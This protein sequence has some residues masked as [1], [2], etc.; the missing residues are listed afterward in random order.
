MALKRWSQI[1]QELA[2]RGPV[3]EK[4]LNELRS[5]YLDALAREGSFFSAAPE[6]QSAVLDELKESPPYYKEGLAGVGQSAW[7][8]LT[9]GVSRLPEMG[10]IGPRTIESLLNRLGIPKAVGAPD[11]VSESGGLFQA[12]L[13]KVSEGIKYLI[14]G[15]DESVPHGLVQNVAAGAAGLPA[16]LIRLAPF[17]AAGAATAG[18]ATP[19]LAGRVATAASLENGVPLALTG[20]AKI[21]SNSLA[22][23]VGF[24]GSTAVEAFNQT[25]VPLGD[26]AAETAKSTAL[27]AALGPAGA[28]SSPLL[29][30]LAEAG[31][32]A[33]GAVA[34]STDRIFS[35]GEPGDQARA[36]ALVQALLPLGAHGVKKLM[37][38]DRKPG[39]PV[40][41]VKTEEVP[42]ESVPAEVEP[43]RRDFTKK[44]DEVYQT[45][46]EA[47]LEGQ[48]EP[49]QVLIRSLFEQKPKDEW[50]GKA[51]PVKTEEVPP[52]VGG[53]TPPVRPESPKPEP[54]PVAEPVKTD[55]QDPQDVSTEEGFKAFVRKSGL[56][57]EEVESVWQEHL[58]ETGQAPVSDEPVSLTDP[59]SLANQMVV[60]LRS[61]EIDGRHWHSFLDFAAR[62]LGLAEEDGRVNR[63]TGN[64]AG[65]QRFL[66]VK[67]AASEA[68]LGSKELAGLVP[69]FEQVGAPRDPRPEHFNP[70]AP[71][72][73][74]AGLLKR[75]S[76]VIGYQ[77]LRNEADAKFG[78]GR[79][80][81]GKPTVKS[82]QAKVKT[83]ELD[84]SYGMD[85][86]G[87]VRPDARAHLAP[88]EVP[89]ATGREVVL[90]SSGIDESLGQE[91][92][93]RNPET[94]EPIY[95]GVRSDRAKQEFQKELPSRKAL[96]VA[97]MTD[98]G[99]GAQIH[100]AV[101]E[102][103]ANIPRGQQKVN[104][105][106]ISTWG[107]LLYR[108]GGKNP[109]EFLREFA[110]AA[111]EHSTPELFGR[112]EKEYGTT[113]A[114]KIFYGSTAS[115]STKNSSVAG[116]YDNRNPRKAGPYARRVI[117]LYRAATPAIFRHEIG[118]LMYDLLPESSKQILHGAI[119][120][121]KK[122]DKTQ[123]E[124]AADL[125]RRYVETG[126]SLPGLV[127]ETRA[128]REWALENSQKFLGDPELRKMLTPAVES[129]LNRLARGEP[130]TPFVDSSGG[131]EGSASFSEVPTQPAGSGKTEQE[132]AFLERA[133]EGSVKDLRP[134]THVTTRPPTAI[135]DGKDT[136]VEL[137]G[138]G[139]RKS[140]AQ[141]FKARKGLP[142]NEV[143]YVRFRQREGELSR[144][145]Y[146]LEMPGS[147]P[148]APVHGAV[149]SVEG[150]YGETSS[151]SAAQA[152]LRDLAA[153]GK[154]RQDQ[155]EIVS[156]YYRFLSRKVGVDPARNQ[157]LYEA[158]ASIKSVDPADPD[159]P[160]RYIG[161]EILDG[162]A[163]EASYDPKTRTTSWF[164][165]A[166]KE[167]SGLRLTWESFF[168]PLER[169][170]RDSFEGGV[171]LTNVA[172][173]AWHLAR[174]LSQ[175]YMESLNKTLKPLD[176]EGVTRFAS[177]V[178]LGQKPGKGL[179]KDLPE[180]SKALEG[181]GPR[182]A[183]VEKMIFE[184]RQGDQRSSLDRLLY[185]KSL[186]EQLLRPEL[187][188]RIR[189][190]GFYAS[191][192]DQWGGARGVGALEVI[193]RKNQAKL[194]R[195]PAEEIDRILSF[196]EEA[197]IP[198]TAAAHD[199][200][201]I[202]SRIAT[203]AAKARA[204]SRNGGE[205]F[206]AFDE[207]L[208]GSIPG[209]QAEKDLRAYRDLV[210][211]RNSEGSLNLLV[212]K[213]PAMRKAQGW[214]ISAALTGRAILGNSIS[215][216]S[217][218][219]LTNPAQWTDAL[220]RTLRKGGLRKESGVALG[221]VYQSPGAR[222]ALSQFSNIHPFAY[223]ERFVR[224]FAKNLGDVRLEK[225]KK[226][227]A[228]QDRRALRELARFTTD[229][230][231]LLR[232]GIREAQEPGSL[233][234]LTALEMA[235]QYALPM[236]KWS[237]P[238]QWQANQLVKVLTTLKRFS[239][240][241][242]I[243]VKNATVKNFVDG[244]E[245]WR[246]GDRANGIKL[247]NEAAARLAGFGL[248]GAVAGSLVG[249][250]WTALT[251]KW[252]QSVFSK[253]KGMTDDDRNDAIQT[254]ELYIKAVVDSG[255]TG[256]MADLLG[257]AGR[258]V[259][260]Q[261]SNLGDSVI[262][263]N[264]SRL[265]DTLG[266]MG[267]FTGGLGEIS[268]AILKE[269]GSEVKTQLR[270]TARKTWNFGENVAPILKTSEAPRSWGARGLTDLL[271]PGVE[272]RRLQR[273]ITDSVK[274]KDRPGAQRALVAY[275][276]FARKQ[277][278]QAR[279]PEDRKHWKNVLARLT[280]VRSYARIKED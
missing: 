23:G 268:R 98:P 192:R 265:Q 33:G 144:D 256:L 108:L 275:R 18:A 94:G 55:E 11:W 147:T 20:L 227:A 252:D 148:A 134:E 121:G 143:K 154:T 183:E 257:E 24:G 64:P 52:E 47:A 247:M 258:L 270:K 95:L 197:N 1:L 69:V 37:G 241:Q 253:A 65:V 167:K 213:S 236:D 74:L 140:L 171:K 59:Q 99:L 186:I 152:L 48:P 217:F 223:S 249:G 233:T 170:V 30:A 178:V 199:P 103:G 2:A 149:F 125:L 91:I 128:L 126:E 279:A 235:R 114:R 122:L 116:L 193:L 29:R 150:E 226:R 260:G 198:S 109:E 119:G 254:F 242:F 208:Q 273:Q 70:E 263:F 40:K 272:A 163:L 204:F 155:Y 32:F 175:P 146:A 151:R 231:D 138:A 39:E 245:W 159:A 71:E 82:I 85:S 176:R 205:V 62:A 112:L 49:I 41:P 21:L 137:Y 238:A 277:L 110:V 31:L 6:E 168:K 93:T 194:E 164:L 79:A 228:A 274:A 76:R 123:K 102:S 120:A 57:E 187:L 250:I 43:P 156:N 185:H 243:Q 225:L 261:K 34:G 54:E 77:K 255:F 83:G 10:F 224:G 202:I 269:N 222:D 25:D 234:D 117:F 50:A 124:T 36:E 111:G 219:P 162:T 203:D 13:D 51:E 262:G 182:L 101:V 259:Q 58:R 133:R 141:A 113:L 46:I 28:I 201:P 180:V 244:L 246:K 240:H 264:L 271:D 214:A 53:V 3:S 166:T 169:V 215:V 229:I 211:D 12:G 251:G 266:F 19:L 157:H 216:L 60:A 280:S 276:T 15:D 200:G 44:T 173:F 267:D 206:R 45:D 7:N 239:L 27:G 118:H 189:S 8:S 278:S 145:L 56:S 136:P 14:P 232:E 4:D 179:L 104:Q 90:E 84:T 61:G 220:A 16:D 207:A 38:I 153:H 142:G 88:R 81:R 115:L 78:S 221:G 73:G 75:L 248:T 92:E 181:W 9:E 139:E 129:E 17:L 96:I 212:F 97:A 230:H 106:I 161:L 210:F 135:I 63:N 132:R 131:G 26:V 72:G 191:E 87:G 5:E 174:Q 196:L 184:Q 100:R 209:T 177:A 80:T 127:E 218:M 195:L 86:L 158:L 160:P 89:V 105:A 35:E 107:K 68:M 67:K 42:P 165:K 130:E 188:R 172:N 22:A 237:V 66:K 190:E